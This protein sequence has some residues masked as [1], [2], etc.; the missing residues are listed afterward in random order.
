MS[1]YFGVLFN[2]YLTFFKPRVDKYQLVE[3]S[4]STSQEKTIFNIR[5]LSSIVIIYWIEPNNLQLQC[6]IFNK[7]WHPVSPSDVWIEFWFLIKIKLSFQGYQDVFWRKKQYVVMVTW[8]PGNTKKVSGNSKY[9]NHLESQSVKKNKKLFNMLDG[10]TIYPVYKGK[11]YLCSSKSNSTKWTGF[12]ATLK[13]C[14]FLPLHYYTSHI[15]DLKPRI[16][17]MGTL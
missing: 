5:N 14:H 3:K 15:K 17:R 7:L 13:R 2:I 4:L 10:E 12:V 11:K 9:L 16:E 6:T 1:L 8:P